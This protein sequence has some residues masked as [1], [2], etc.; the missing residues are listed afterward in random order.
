MEIFFPEL[1]D[2]FIS[3]YFLEK[4][5]NKF[6]FNKEQTALI[7]V[8]AKKMLPTIRE[9][10]FYV[11]QAYF[12][13][14][15]PSTR[16]SDTTYECV[17][18]SLGN[19][20]DLLQ[21]SYSEKGLLLESYIVEVLASELLLQGYDAYN[22]YIAEHTAQ[23]VARYYFPG[24]EKELPLEMLPA[25]LQNLTQKILCNSAFYMQPKKSVVY[26]AELTQDETMHCKAICVGCTNK[27][28]PHRIEENKLIRK[29][30]TDLPLT[31]GY[32]RIFG[33]QA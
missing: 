20:V 33:I 10:A 18:M 31:Y 21:E 24:N 8:V 14:N 17:A 26:I 32:S 12:M 19:G 2:E 16:N 4:V 30:L 27:S 6:H 5:R 28:C 9:E 25:L 1:L 22:S 13:D 3:D 29:K 23:H 15:K 11:R 7:N